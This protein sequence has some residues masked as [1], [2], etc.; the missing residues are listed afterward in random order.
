MTH[1]KA[2]LMRALRDA[3]AMERHAEW[4]L[5]SHVAATT[6]YPEV[7]ERIDADLTATLAN[8]K[9]L[10]GCMERIEGTDG[11]DA[12]LPTLPDEV[13]GAIETGSIAQTAGELARN[14]GILMAFKRYEIAS[15]LSLIAAAEASGF[16]ETKFTCE[17]ILSQQVAMAD[18]LF[19]CVPSSGD[20][21]TGRVRPSASAPPPSPSVH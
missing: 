8:Q 18:W 11:S 10:A 16:F 7:N 21:S 12:I 14:L 9:A 15:Y 2:D 3:C 1:L 4:L 17:G 5:R 6:L 19:D 13:A 20:T